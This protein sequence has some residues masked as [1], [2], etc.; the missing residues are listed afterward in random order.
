MATTVINLSAG[1][2]YSL[3][4]TF[5]GFD[6]SDYSEIKAHLRL[7]RDGAVISHDVRPDGSDAKLG[8]VDWDATDIVAGDHYL[9]F[10]FTR[11]ADGRVFT[12]PCE[13]PINVRVRPKH[14]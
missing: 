1:D 5:T 10:K 11:T 4:V 12:L 7:N 2:T 9:E 8:Y 14:Y 13:A 3:P 6:L